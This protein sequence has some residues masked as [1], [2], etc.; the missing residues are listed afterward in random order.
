MDFRGGQQALLTLARGLRE[1][2]HA[3]VIMSPAGSELERRARQLEF[4]VAGLSLKE[5]RACMKGADL[6]HAHT[7]RAQNM[8]FLASAGL[9]IKRIV[10]RHVAFSPRY[11]LVHRLKYSNT[12]DGVIA[13]SQAVRRALLDA[14]VPADRIEV[15]PTGVKIPAE[16]P[17]AAQRAEARRAWKLD[18]GD[19][20]VGHLGAFTHE[21]GQ[22]VAARAA[23]LL[24]GRL[25]RLKMILAGEGPLRSSIP[26][27]DRL[28]L[29]GHIA[30][31]RQLLAALDLFVMPSRS[32]GWGLAALE[33]MA[34]GLPVVA[35][36]TGGLAEMIVAGETGWLVLP[37]NAPALA[38]TIFEA[39]GDRERLHAM[40]LRARECARRFSVEETA[41]RTEA[42]YLRVLKGA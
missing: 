1:R 28:I 39:E 5:L 35:S 10:T 34:F 41:S 12:C 17:D 13:V 31:P 7:G 16:L 8:A 15:I 18:D 36:N 3:Q 14:G 9:G 4:D 42:L 21:K 19:F 11:P 24:E 32:E 29:P 2:G 25:P 27:S 38:D 26:G 6:L 23:H 22:D 30:E 20:A 40:G 37:E 33:A